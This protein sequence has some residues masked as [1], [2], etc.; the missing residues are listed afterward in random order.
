MELYKSQRR[1]MS[2]FEEDQTEGNEE[3]GHIDMKREIAKNMLNRGFDH[4]A[5]SKATALSLKEIEKLFE[6]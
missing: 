1:L 5:I 2:D 6:E 4:E 3:E